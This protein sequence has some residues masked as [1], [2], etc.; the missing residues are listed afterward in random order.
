M[1]INSARGAHKIDKWDY[2]SFPL[3]NAHSFKCFEKEK[4]EEE[5]DSEKL[6][7]QTPN[8]MANV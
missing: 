6:C 7:N 8:E 4:S 2:Y 3:M 1:T 5:L